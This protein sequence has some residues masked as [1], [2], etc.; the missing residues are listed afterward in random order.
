[1]HS[2]IHYIAMPGIS[3]EQ[4][5]QA[6]RRRQVVPHVC[7]MCGTSFKGI[8][9]AI[10]DRRACQVRAYRRRKKE[11]ERQREFR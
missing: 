4:A 10:Y 6:S 8:N 1:M 7:P 5:S 11:A 2:S 3:S 9:G